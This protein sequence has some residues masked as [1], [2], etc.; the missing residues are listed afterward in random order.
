MMNSE[1]PTS[2]HLSTSTHI[3]SSLHHASTSPLNPCGCQGLVHF[4]LTRYTLSTPST[5]TFLSSRTRIPF[6]SCCFNTFSRV[7]LCIMF[8]SHEGELLFSTFR[9]CIANSTVLTNRKYGVATVWYVPLPQSLM[10]SMLTR[11]RLVATLG[12]KSSLKRVTRKQ[13]LDVDV[14]KACKTIVDPV[15]PMALRLQGSLLYT[16]SLCFT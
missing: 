3:S 13:M 6:S 11:C 10:I 7:N 15:A 12:S 16:S 8:Y 4:P 2:A 14:V 1:I 5:Q 9:T